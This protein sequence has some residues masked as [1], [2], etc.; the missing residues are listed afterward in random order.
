MGFIAQSFKEGG[1]M[2]WPILFA[3]FLVYGIAIERIIFLWFRAATNKEEFVRNALKII[4][5]G[6]LSAVVDFVS[7]QNSPLARIV[8]AGL[9]KVRGKDED[10]Q[11]AMDE[12]AL[13]ELPKI[14][15][16]TP[17]LA[18]FGNVAMLLG[19]LGTISG[20]IISFAAVANAEASE[21]AAKLALGISEAMNCTA[22]G[23]IVAI[24][25]LIGYALLN[26]KTQTLID[27]INES[28]VYVLNLVVNNRNKV[29][30]PP[31]GL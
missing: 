14:E 7:T 11:V 2:M 3:S 26:G 15:K 17:Y 18:M 20:M 1:L 28:S 31:A 8:H 16:R 29:N 4:Y 25:G 10:V 12:A 30:L 21:K 22:F 5:K 27:D 24:S 9:L 13:S 6:N 19:L 23:L